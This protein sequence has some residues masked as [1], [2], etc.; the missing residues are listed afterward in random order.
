MYNEQ[1]NAH[2]IYSLLYR[3]FVYFA[4]TSL[5]ANASSSGSSYSLPAKLLTR[6]HALLVIF[7]CRKYAVWYKVILLKNELIQNVVERTTNN[8]HYALI[9]TN[10]LF[11][12]LAPTCFGSSLPSSGS[13][14]DPSELL[15]TQI[16]WLVYHIMCG[17]EACKPECRGSVYCA[18]QLSV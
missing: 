9:C 10:F 3:F 6:V 18:S 7:D 13:F 16:E 8:Q 5:N 11:Y 2:L 15:E 17:Y 14:L 1:T 12:V 4:P